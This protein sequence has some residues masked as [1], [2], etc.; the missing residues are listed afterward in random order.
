MATELIRAGESCAFEWSA[1]VMLGTVNPAITGLFGRLG[2]GPV[3]CSDRHADGSAVRARAQAPRRERRPMTG[4]PLVVNGHGLTIADVARV[5]RDSWAV[6]LSDDPAVVAA[7]DSS[8][9]CI[10]DAV[11]GGAR[12]YGV[13]TGYGAMADV[14]ITPADA[15]ELQLNLVWHLK[16]GAGRRLTGDEVR[17]AML[18][19]ANSHLRGASGIGLELVRRLEVFLNA[20]VTPHV[21]EFGSIGASGDLVPLASI[22]G[23]LIGLAPSFRVDVDGD[24]T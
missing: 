3:G 24:E 8:C 21:R 2:Y 1:S 10:R 19:R 4:E 22:T 14:E 6:R 9:A 11:D 13:T 17:A 23:A 7:L 5:A 18:I 15:E 12:I 20:G 16:T